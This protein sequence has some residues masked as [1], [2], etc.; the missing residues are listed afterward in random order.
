MSLTILGRLSHLP[1]TFFQRR[2]LSYPAATMVRAMLADSSTLNHVGLIILPLRL[3]QPHE[4]PCRS[5]H[6]RLSK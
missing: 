3:Q 2:E 6:T 1:S 4:V 5:Q